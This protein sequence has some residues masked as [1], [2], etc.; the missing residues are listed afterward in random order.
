M[1]SNSI[2]ATQPYYANTTLLP[3]TIG[4]TTGTLQGGVQFNTPGAAAQYASSNGGQVGQITYNDGNYGVTPVPGG[5]ASLGGFVDST[6]G[7]SMPNALLG[8]RVNVPGDPNSINEQPGMAYNSTPGPTSGGVQQQ[9]YNPYLSSL[10]SG[11]AAPSNTLPPSSTPFAAAA[12]APTI[13]PMASPMGMRAAPSIAAAPNMVS[14]ANANT[15]PSGMGNPG[16]RPFMPMSGPTAG[17]G[18]MPGQMPTSPNGMPIGPGTVMPQAMGGGAMFSPAQS[19]SGGAQAAFKP[20]QT[21]LQ[22]GVSMNAPGGGAPS[23]GGGGQPGAGGAMGGTAVAQGGG[24]SAGPM[25]SLANAA[26]NVMKPMVNALGQVL[27]PQAASAATPGGKQ[28]PAHDPQVPDQILA[29]TLA[30]QKAADTA[31]AAAKAHP[32]DINK[33]NAVMQQSM[34]A[35]AKAVKETY[36]TILTPINDRETRFAAEVEQSKDLNSQMRENLE[37]MAKLTSYGEAQRRAQAAVDAGWNLLT[38]K[39]QR[40]RARVDPIQMLSHGAYQREIHNVA[41]QKAA[42]VNDLAPKIYAQMTAERKGL[43]EQMTMEETF[44]KNLNDERRQNSQDFTNATHSMYG[45]IAAAQDKFISSYSAQLVANTAANKD[46]QQSAQDLIL[47]ARNQ[48]MENRNDNLARLADQRE[49]DKRVMDMA[50]MQH[51]V[52]DTINKQKTEQIAEANAKTKAGA[53]MGHL[54]IQLENA[55]TAKKKANQSTSAIDNM[56]DELKKQMLA[57]AELKNQEKAMAK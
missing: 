47:E 34:D 27:T 46:L 15:M 20:L 4:S 51:M 10:L 11:L 25:Q 48:V 21:A 23:G 24:M 33:S 52:D 3:P 36:T 18:G 30:A 19:Q 37:N 16:A 50:K 32:F 28:I 54:L 31:I 42:A 2:F 9:T 14:G 39:E 26:G 1:G 45:D 22:G 56:I 49:A 40:D 53:D 8:T 43:E 7:P 41:L 12:P 29:A 55:Q 5:G 17:G 44:R 38:P 6:P 13:S 35:I 57:D